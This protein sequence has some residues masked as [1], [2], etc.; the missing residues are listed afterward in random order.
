MAELPLLILSPGVDI[1]FGGESYCEPVS[2]SEIINLG[3]IEQDL[4][5]SLHQDFGFELR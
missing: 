1:S 3:S 4:S 5:W 2:Q